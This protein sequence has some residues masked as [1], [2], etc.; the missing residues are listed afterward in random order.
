MPKSSKKMSS[1]YEAHSLEVRAYREGKGRYTI[2]F[3]TH[4][5]WRES[6][7]F[8][9]RKSDPLN[10]PSSFGRV[11][12]DSSLLEGQDVRCRWRRDKRTPVMLSRATRFSRWGRILH[13]GVEMKISNLSQMSM[14][15]ACVGADLVGFYPPQFGSFLYCRHRLSFSAVFLMSDPSPK[16]LEYWREFAFIDVVG[17]QISPPK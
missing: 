13:G 4:V 10:F 3:G 11:P 1:T 8:T 7:I 17:D 9:P 16:S 2:G 5:K 15:A 12:V 6:I 14:D